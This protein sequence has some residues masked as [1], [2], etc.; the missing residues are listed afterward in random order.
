[1]ERSEQIRLSLLTFRFLRLLLLTPHVWS[2]P[3][4]EK[5]GKRWRIVENKG[6]RTSMRAEDTVLINVSCIPLVLKQRIT[7]PNPNGA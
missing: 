1:M 6:E 3:Y 2:T 7:L 4:G 5:R